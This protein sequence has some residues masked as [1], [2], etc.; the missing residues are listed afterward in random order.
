[1][2]TKLTQS[3]EYRGIIRRIPDNYTSVIVLGLVMFIGILIALGIVIH[4]PDKVIAEVRVTSTSPPNILNANSNGKLI[5][6]KSQLPHLFEPNEYIAV[7]ENPA[8]PNDIKLLK[9]ILSQFNIHTHA[10]TISVDSIRHN[11]LY[12]GEIEPLYFRFKEA[13]LNYEFLLND[14]KYTYEIKLLYQKIYNDSLYI[15]TQEQILANH[16]IQHEIFYQRFRTDSI[17]LSQMAILEYAHD[18]TYLTLLNS[19]RTTI[20]IRSEI[21]SKNRSI[22]D[23][24]LRIRSAMNEYEIELNNGHL[25]LIESYH[26][27]IAGIREWEKQYVFMSS[28]QGTVEYANLLHNNSFVSVGEPVFN[29]IYEDNSF[30]AIAILPSVGAGKVAVGQSTN[31]KIDLYPYQEFGVLEGAVSSI[32]LN[33]VDRSYIVYIALP[34]GLVSSTNHT[35]SFAET[36]YGQ[37]EIITGNKRLLTKIFHHIYILLNPSKKRIEEPETSS[38]KPFFQL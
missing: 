6:L 14:N 23:S 11:V 8:N 28:Q 13:L 17:L 21:E 5:L 18:N 10:Y 37:A 38:K 3:Q 31:L 2:E 1:M 33:S 26:N 32:S 19:E 34:N 24:R 22:T 4:A 27:L 25:K 9:E 35:L 15:I 16:I 7:I 12:L 20:S 30:Y 29:V 36:M